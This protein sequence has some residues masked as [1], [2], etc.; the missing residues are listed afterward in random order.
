LKTDMKKLDIVISLPGENRYLAE[1]AVV[2]KATAHRLDVDLRIINAHSDPVSQSQQ[3]LELIQSPPASRPNAIIVEPATEN[4]LPRVADAAVSAGIG[5]VISN[6]RVDYL[7]QLRRN[8]KVPVFSISQDHSEIG[9]LQARQFAAILP[10]GGT[11]LYLRGP[12]T[13]YLASQRAEA[14]EAAAPRNV[15]VKALKIQWTEENCFQSVSSWLRLG[16]VR[17]ADIGLIA[18]QNTD[19]VNGARRALQGVG[20]AAER[21]KWLAIR[22]TGAGVASQTRSLVDG[23]VLAAA[24]I[25]SLTM[26]VA[27]EM[28]VK[29]LENSS[30]PTEHTFVSASS[31]PNLEDLARKHAARLAATAK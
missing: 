26:D 20:D 27:L 1:Q 10:E 21:A 17:A 19:F 24:V 29:A 3:L 31:Y 30:Q 22:C 23:G 13:N 4:G 7:E 9:R 12:G 2:A 5:W 25:T 6:A 18:S 11:V 16:T 8:G 14:M 15:R 28:L